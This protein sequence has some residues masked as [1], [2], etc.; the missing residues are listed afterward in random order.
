M[1]PIYTSAKF[2]VVVCFTVMPRTVLGTGDTANK[3]RELYGAYV[4]GRS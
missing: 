4:L 2:I 3:T 1:S